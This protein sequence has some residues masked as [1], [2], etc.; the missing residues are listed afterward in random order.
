VLTS[1]PSSS[2]DH[3]QLT[4]GDTTQILLGSFGQ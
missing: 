2:L 1:G 4:R 3:R